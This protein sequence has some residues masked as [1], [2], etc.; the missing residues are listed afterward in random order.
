MRLIGSKWVYSNRLREIKNEGVDNNVR[1]F[2]KLNIIRI[3]NCLLD[4]VGR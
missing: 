4:F 1:G 3:E 2:K